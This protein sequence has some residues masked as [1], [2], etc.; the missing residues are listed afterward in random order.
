M[1][2]RERGFVN[3]GLA[4]ARALCLHAVSFPLKR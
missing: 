1:M 3:F 4:P 2:G